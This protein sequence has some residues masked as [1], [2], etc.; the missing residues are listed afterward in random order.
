MN[1]IE[2]NKKRL[3]HKNTD[4]P[5][6]GSNSIGRTQINIMGI[7][8]YIPDEMLSEPIIRA[9][10][11][12]DGGLSLTSDPKMLYEIT[13]EYSRTRIKYDFQYWAATC[14]VIKDK[15]SENE[16][17][18]ILNRPQKRMLS[19]LE[20][21]R[22]ND[23]P[24]RVIML[25]ARQWGGSTLVQ[26][27]MAWIQL[28]HRK[29]WNSL[30]CAQLDSASKNIRGMYTRLMAKYPEWATDSN[31]HVEFKP[32]EGSSNT[33]IIKDRGCVV[34][35]GSAETPN[36]IRSSDIVMA[37]LSEVAF[38]RNTEKTKVADLIS[39][40]SGSIKNLPYSILVMESTAK[41]TGN[42]FHTEYMRSKEGKSDK[43]AFFVPWFEIEMYSEPIQDYENFLSGLTEYHYWLFEQGA[44]LENIAWYINKRKEFQTDSAMHE[45]YPSDDV[46]AFNTT[47]ERVFDRYKVEQMRVHCFPPMS[48]GEIYGRSNKGRE[49]LADLK[50]SEEETGKLS[51]WNMPESGYINRYLTVVDV[52]G[53]S[54]KADYSVI[55]VFDRKAQIENG[56]PKIVA[57]WY[58]HTDHDLLAWKAAQI[59]K[60]YFDALL[61]IESNT[62]ETE[63]TDGEHTEYILDEIK[64]SYSNLYSR[65]PAEAIIEGVPQK[66]GF[67]M[68]RS[69]KAMIIDHMVCMLREGGYIERFMDACH[70]MDVFEKKQNGSFGAIDGHHDDILITRMI[71]AYI[72]YEIPPPKPKTQ[73]KPK[74]K[75][76]VGYS[77]M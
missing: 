76:M 69:T 39:S 32:F 9:L 52:G 74:T 54:K 65:T 31:Q 58:G 57:Q 10:A 3:N 49:S 46:E 19:V 71:G 75:K 42:F 26:I 4:N 17:P 50:F 12:T 34:S 27:Y 77:S 29:N 20:D 47:G 13:L 73:I 11:K 68:N 62:Y 64:E 56:A 28:V 5:V 23:K 8:H 53:R 43:V 14:V 55:A 15:N 35:V 61:V 70:E 72:C 2:E 21:L 67:H 1:Y 6:I 40:I 41:G 30:I 33:K 51:I 25:K 66:W 7:Y 36:S 63:H 38:Y 16:I 44:T 59:A 37:H 24:I 45:E 18:F 48:I 22:K 60:F